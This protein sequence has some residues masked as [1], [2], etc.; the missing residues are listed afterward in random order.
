M[1]F[2]FSCEKIHTN[3]LT[4]FTDNVYL[5]SQHSGGEG[6]NTT[7]RFFIIFAVALLSV[8]FLNNEAFTA[9]PENMNGI[10]EG[11]WMVH[12]SSMGLLHGEIEFEITQ[13]GKKIT[14]N[15][16]RMPGMPRWGSGLT[17]G[18]SKNWVIL[19]FSDGIHRINATLRGDTL[20]GQ[21]CGGSACGTIKVQRK[22]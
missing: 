19:D 7:I 5:I 18:I 11:S 3:D 2:C 16:F 12:S 13:V 15:V 22:K 20:D 4:R 17:G 8:M 9:D 14:G 10:W 6:M 1:S 21:L